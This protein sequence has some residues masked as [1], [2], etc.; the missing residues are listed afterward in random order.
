MTNNEEL[1]ALV[2]CLKKQDA[3]FVEK[4]DNFILESRD[5]RKKIYEEVKEVKGELRLMNGSV[6]GVLLW[7]ERIRGQVDMLKILFIPV[8]L[9]IVS[10][11]LDKF[12]K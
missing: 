6:K 10:L 2:N 4:I 11:Y 12:L 8:I 7:K 1:L 5:D 3:V 9:A